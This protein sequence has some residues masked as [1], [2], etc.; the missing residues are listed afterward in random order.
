VAGGTP[1]VGDI[2][3]RPVDR[4]IQNEGKIMKSYFVQ[5]A[6]LAF[7]GCQDSRFSNRRSI[8]AI[9]HLLNGSEAVFSSDDTARKTLK[10]EICS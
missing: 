3:V 8:Q 6:F 5:D 7:R 4:G 9:K 10:R 2:L 1:G